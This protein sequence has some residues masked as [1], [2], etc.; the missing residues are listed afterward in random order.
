MLET[1]EQLPKGDP[2]IPMSAG[3]VND[4]AATV[5]LFKTERELSNS[6]KHSAL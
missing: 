4:V 5:K 2:A 3:K 6:E 1:S